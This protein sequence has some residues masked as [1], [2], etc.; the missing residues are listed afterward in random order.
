MDVKETG[1]E[2]AQFQLSD[3]HKKAIEI[4]AGDRKVKLDGRI[5]HGKLRIV[6]IHILPVGA[7][8]S[9]FDPVE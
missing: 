9:A 4:L 6:G 5:E 7:C 1:R 2:P 8:N 3:E